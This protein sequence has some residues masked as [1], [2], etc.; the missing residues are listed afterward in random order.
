MEELNE[1]Y[2]EREGKN[3]EFVRSFAWLV[4]VLIIIAAVISIAQADRQSRTIAM[5]VT[6]YCPCE[7]C[8]QGS[9]DGITA[10]GH[11]IRPGEKFVAADKRYTF[12]TMLAIPGY[13]GGRPVPVWDRGGAIKGD[14]L[15]VFFPT[16]KEALIWGVK[17][18]KVEIK[19]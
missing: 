7:K 9:A 15:D 3:V 6:A 8:C 19:R 2:R 12:G 11:R 16:H 13:N 18:L 5:R 17:Y 1:F 10:N 4:V 14:K